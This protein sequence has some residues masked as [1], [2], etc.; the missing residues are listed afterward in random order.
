[1]AK[2]AGRSRSSLSRFNS[3]AHQ[4]TCLTR[5]QR[6]DKQIRNGST[7]GEGVEN[8]WATLWPSSQVVRYISPDYQLS[9]LPLLLS[10]YE[11]SQPIRIIYDFG[12]QFCPPLS[13]SML[14]LNKDEEPTDLPALIADVGP[15]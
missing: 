7:E 3:Q 5:N 11:V 12:A 4:Q 13:L 14:P 10:I 15:Y 1:M 2:N 8:L 6:R 9:L